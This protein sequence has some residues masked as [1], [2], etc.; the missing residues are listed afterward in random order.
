M[1]LFLPLTDEFLILIYNKVHRFGCVCVLFAHFV[2][3]SFT[4]LLLSLCECVVAV[5]VVVRC[6]G[7]CSLLLLLCCVSVLADSSLGLLFE[8]KVMCVYVCALLLARYGFPWPWSCSGSIEPRP[9]LLSFLSGLL[10]VVFVVFVLFGL[11]ENF[12]RPREFPVRFRG[13]TRAPTRTGEAF[14][15]DTKGKKERNTHKRLSFRTQRKK[16]GERERERG[17]DRQVTE[18]WLVWRRAARARLRH[19]GNEAAALV[20]R[21]T[22][23]SDTT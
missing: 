8:R 16:Q 22:L 5:V 9:V 4:V 3:L 18:S 2:S 7:G 6:R 15:S 12:Q 17:R 14:F 1:W 10:F 13:K 19:S 11:F 23:A 21:M 20:L